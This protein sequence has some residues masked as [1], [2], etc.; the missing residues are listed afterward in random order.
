MGFT[1]IWPSV[2]EFHGDRL[3]TVMSDLF[4]SEVELGI[5]RS[6]PS[7]VAP[8]ASVPSMPAAISPSPPPAAVP[9]KERVVSSGTGFFVAAD[10]L[11]TNAHVVA[12]CEKVNVLIDGKGVEGV[13]R[14]RDTTNDLAIVETNDYRSATFAKMR[15]GVRLGEDVAA[16]GFPLSGELASSGNFTRGAVTAT[17]GLRDD[18]AHLQ[19]DRRSATR[20]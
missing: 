2:A 15:P 5:P 11:L 7:P 1:L 9:E 20:Q 17:A 4:R 10:R 14:G 19:T 6:P 8:I 18:I 12:G 16:F 3:A 13:V